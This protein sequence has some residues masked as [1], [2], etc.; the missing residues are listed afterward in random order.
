MSFSSSQPEGWKMAV[1]SVDG[2]TAI[3]LTR[4]TDGV[5]VRGAFPSAQGLMGIV[6]DELHEKASAL[7][8]A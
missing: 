6:L 1:A 7:D 5:K 3:E 4:Q 8:A 2:Y